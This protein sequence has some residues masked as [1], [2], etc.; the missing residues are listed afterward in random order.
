MQRAPSCRI[1]RP[2]NRSTIYPL[3]CNAST[4]P[5]SISLMRS[6][7]WWPPSQKMTSRQYVCI[8][9]GV[10][11]LRTTP[12]RRTNSTGMG[13]WATNSESKSGPV[14]EQ[15][16][17]VLDWASSLSNY[18][19]NCATTRAN[20]SMV[21]AL[22]LS[23]TRN[24]A[25]GCR[26]SNTPSRCRNSSGGKASIRAWVAPGNRSFSSNRIAGAQPARG[27]WGCGVVA[28][29]SRDDRAGRAG[30]L[31]AVDLGSG[32]ATDFV[33]TRFNEQSP[34]FSPDGR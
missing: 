28:G 5:V 16:H 15:V 14:E 34:S 30:D 27:C 8:E 11:G 10:V 20:G 25:A 7:P 2:V 18:A 22:P 26:T 1:S 23:G 4:T 3:A 33:A 17:L 9:S 31:R 12:V 32:A 6:S 21:L 19:I 13:C 24:A 29:R